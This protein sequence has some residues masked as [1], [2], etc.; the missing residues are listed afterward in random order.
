MGENPSEEQTKEN[1][2]NTRKGGNI[3]A[4]L[5]PKNSVIIKGAKGNTSLERHRKLA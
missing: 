5:Q 4:E 3:A 1:T 2:R